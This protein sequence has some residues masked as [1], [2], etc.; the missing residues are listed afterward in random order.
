MAE[1]IVL[2]TSTRKTT[3]SQRTDS[4][5]DARSRIISVADADAYLKMCIYS[6]NGVGKTT[7]IGSSDLKTL[8][9]DCKEKGWVS[10]RKNHPNVDV[11][12]MRTWADFD[13]IFWLLKSSNHG[14]QVLGVDTITMMATI[15]MKWILK[16]DASRDFSR[17]PMMPDKRHWGKLGEILKNLII[18]LRDLPM[19]V[20][21]AAQEK[22]TTSEDDEGGVVQEVHPELSPS[23]RSTLLSAVSIIG[24]LYARE[25]ELEG[26]KKRMERRM[27]L[28]AH[29]KFVSKNRFDELRPIERNPTLAKFIARIEGEKSG[30]SSEQDTS[31]T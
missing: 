20:I 30:S 28:G 24:R 21:F 3:K 22:M 26:G 9:I 5:A 14:Y 16:D 1:A 11:Y 23:P 10:I 8:I 27:L 4:I 17:D 19:H 13:P 2:T 15:A 12:P 6:R 18:D 31:K 7:F 29:T 25:V